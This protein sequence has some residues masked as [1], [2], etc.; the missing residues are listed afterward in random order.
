MSDSKS[1]TNSVAIVAIIV[2]GILVGGA[3]FAYFADD[4]PK[5]I[6]RHTTVEKPQDDTGFSFEYKSEDGSV[7]IEGD[8]TEESQ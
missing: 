3:G 1:G 8:N 5:V 7:K 4:D 2:V 6:E